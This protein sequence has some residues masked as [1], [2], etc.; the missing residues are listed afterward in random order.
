MSI[1]TPAREPKPALQVAPVGEH[2]ATVFCLHGLGGSGDGWLH[3]IDD[4]KKREGLKDVKWV[5]PNAYTRRAITANFGQ[6]MPGWYNVLRID[7]SSIA[8]QEDAEG[9]WSSVER[10]HGVLDEEVTAGIPSE[11]IVLAGFSQGAAVTMASGLTYSKKLAGIAVLSGYLMRELIW[12]VAQRK[13]PFVPELP[14][15]L[16]HGNDDAVVSMETSETSVQ[17]LKDK[18]GY[19]PIEEKGKF[20]VMYYEDV[21]HFAADEEIEDLVEWLEEVLK[22]KQD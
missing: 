16:A 12:V 3:V 4:M 5:L 21:G 10:I 19:K 11:Q 15:F 8:R 9:L 2:K 14:F 17:S 22:V 13:S 1:T 18:F 7:D 6:E 20:T